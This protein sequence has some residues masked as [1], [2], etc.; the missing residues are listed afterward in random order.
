MFVT[1]N[2]ETWTQKQIEFFKA[3]YEDVAVE[4]GNEIEIIGMQVKMDRI[5]KKVFL[6]QPKN[7]DKRLCH[8]CG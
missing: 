7:V 1:S 8:V 6:T 5:D 2:D 4:M 3:Q